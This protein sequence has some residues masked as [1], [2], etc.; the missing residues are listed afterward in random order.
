ME[1]GPLET[2]EKIK[3]MLSERKAH[4]EIVAVQDASCKERMGN[5]RTALALCKR[6]QPSLIDALS[7]IE[8]TSQMFEVQSTRL[9]SIEERTKISCDIAWITA[10]VDQGVDLETILQIW[11]NKDKISPAETK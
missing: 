11:L 5:L 2:A 7:V 10:M 9:N 4:L 6:P 1:K 8:L 3:D